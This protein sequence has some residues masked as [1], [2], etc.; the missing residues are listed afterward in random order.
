MEPHKCAVWQWV[1]WSEVSTW[2][3]GQADAEKASEVWEGK[4]LFLPI[5]NLF[6]QFPDF[7]VIT[8]YNSATK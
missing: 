2:A 1:N 4:Y 8:A 5:V 6:R 3:R 7:N